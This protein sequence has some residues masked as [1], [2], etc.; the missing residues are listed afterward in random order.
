MLSH[1]SV[2]Y[3]W[4]YFFHL[5]FTPWKQLAAICIMNSEHVSPECVV[6]AMLRGRLFIRVNYGDAWGNT[7]RIRRSVEQFVELGDT[8]RHW[9]LSTVCQHI[10]YQLYYDE[11]DAPSW[12][13][14][15]TAGLFGVATSSKCYPLAT[16][17][18]RNINTHNDNGIELSIAIARCTELVASLTSLSGDNKYSKPSNKP[19]QKHVRY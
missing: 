12:C 19:A 5:Y 4:M 1:G 10:V 13:S 2:V 11:G 16:H 14:R 18:G 7:V 8:A 6:T 9:G 3:T 15:R 17:N